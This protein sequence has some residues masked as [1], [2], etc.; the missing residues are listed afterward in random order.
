MNDK[1]QELSKKNHLMEQV[2][3]K[4]SESKLLKYGIAVFTQRWQSVPVTI[5]FLRG[6]GLNFAAARLRENRRILV[7]P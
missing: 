2:L 6:N 1:Q 4:S 5:M 3:L 7:L